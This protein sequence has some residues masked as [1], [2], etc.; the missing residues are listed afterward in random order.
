MTNTF[1]LREVA[2]RRACGFTLIEM[3][4]ALAI[5]AVLVGIAAPSFKGT[6]VRYRMGS[7][8]SALLDSLLLARDE[9]RNSAS[10]VSVCASRDGTSCN[11]TA[12]SDG[13]IVFRDQGTA[14]TVDAGDTVISRAPAA[15]SGITTVATLQQSGVAYTNNY[16]QFGG[17]GKLSVRTALLFTTCR[18]GYQPLLT[19]IQYNGSTSSS[20]GAGTCP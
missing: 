18:S 4:V 20:K 6:V 3:M 11:G 16:V 19:A 2:L 17:D 13:H 1:L 10:P 15:K 12:W 5:G 8:S 14:G 9:A 7:E